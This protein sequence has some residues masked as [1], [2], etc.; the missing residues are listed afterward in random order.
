MFLQHD[1]SVSRR[2][3]ACLL[4]TVI[5]YLHSV[6]HIRPLCYYIFL[7]APLC[8]P[9]LF[10]R[11][12]RADSTPSSLSPHSFDLDIAGGSFLWERFQTDSSIVL[13]ADVPGC[14]YFSWDQSWLFDSSLWQSLGSLGEAQMDCR[15]TTP[16]SCSSERRS[17]SPRPIWDWMHYV[18]LL[19]TYLVSLGRGFLH[20][21]LLGY[22]NLSYYSQTL[23]ALAAPF[24]AYHSCPLQWAS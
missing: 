1:C 18:G 11:S 2:W 13:I 9:H 4:R 22:I 20:S 21:V 3:D 24:A 16:S 17:A 12:V 10:H 5:L 8:F 6:F 7:L 19:K 15:Q 14:C 23:E